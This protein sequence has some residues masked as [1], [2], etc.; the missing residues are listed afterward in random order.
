VC[1]GDF[2]QGESAWFLNGTLN[3]SYNCVDRHALAHPN[4]VA[5]IYEPDHPDDP[6]IKITY[7]ELLKQVCQVANG[8]AALGLR[9][10][11]TVGIYMPMVPE[12]AIVCNIFI[13]TNILFDYYKI[14]Y[15]IAAG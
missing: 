13:R 10:G 9:K 8:L 15:F 7:K 4:K 11:D 12:A 14:G 3:V 1:Y 2:H 5:I 6:T